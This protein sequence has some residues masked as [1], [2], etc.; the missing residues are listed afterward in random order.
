MAILLLVLVNIILISFFDTKI[1]F[2]I[3]FFEMISGLITFAFFKRKASAL[4]NVAMST[5]SGNYNS[6]T[7][8]QLENYY[9]LLINHFDFP[10]FFL[11]KNF[12]IKFLNSQAKLSYGK[13]I[14]S[15]ITSV[16]R[17]YEFIENIE[18]YKNNDNLNNF[19]WKKKLP[20]NKSYK[21]EIK[22]FNNFL[23]LQI[24]DLTKEANKKRN[25]ELYLTN[26]THELK[27]PLSVIIGYLETINFEEFSLEENKKFIEIVNSKS[28]EMKNLIDQMLKLS[29]IESLTKVKTKI[30]VYDTINK[31]T[32]SYRELF[33]KK[34][35]NLIV[36]IDKIK[37]KFIEFTPNDFEIV[38]NNLLSNALNYSDS[39]TSVTIAASFISKENQVEIMVKDQG[40]GISNDNLTRI[41]EKFYR[42][43]KSRNNLIHGHGLGLAITNEIIAKNKCKM[44]I[45]S[46]LGK[47]STFKVLCKLS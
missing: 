18:K 11:D 29:E 6:L 34:S 39:N 4:S 26:L 22:K 28:L 12:E 13:K 27:T 2:I 31:S 5:N 16:I 46:N 17:D 33:E 25:H 45:L 7:D 20:E 23:V 37:N 14:L 21:T 32:K 19:L 42:V 40:I 47:G 41:T 35:I 36:D 9:Q 1:I 30:N 3:L 8:V 43:D 15:P 38:L 10:I 24:I 44:L